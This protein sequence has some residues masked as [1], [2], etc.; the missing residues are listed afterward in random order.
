VSNPVVADFESAKRTNK[1]VA[2]K[3][4]MS[5]GDAIQSL[6][7]KCLAAQEGERRRI[8]RELHDGLNQELALMSINLGILHRQIPGESTE[9]VAL[10]SSLRERM[11]F[12]S[13]GLRKITHRLHPAAIEHLGL[14][15]AV[16]NHC[17]EFSQTTQIP[18]TFAVVHALKFPPS[19]AVC[20]Y[21]IVQEALLNVAKH[22]NATKACVKIA[23]AP[24]GILLSIA[25]NGCGFKFDDAHGYEGLGLVSIRERVQAVQGQLIMS[26]A[27]GKGM[28]I[29]VYV[30]VRG[31][32]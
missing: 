10:I 15:A 30:P 8:A 2:A 24:G 32:E 18:V 31:K 22:A 26:S 6:T 4:R 29:E 3:E 5:L 20:L 11:E 7:W 9:Q 21:R 12:L 25:D 16:R 27:P 17:E 19:L 14:I 1:N 28:R 13:D 23:R